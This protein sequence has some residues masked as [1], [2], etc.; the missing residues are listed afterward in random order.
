MLLEK[1]KGLESN[2]SNNTGRF[3]QEQS[4]STYVDAFT[5]GQYFLVLQLEILSLGKFKA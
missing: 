1:L 3:I 4:T 5:I 2:E